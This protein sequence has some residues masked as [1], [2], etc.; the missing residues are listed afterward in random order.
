MKRKSMAGLAG[1]AALSAIAAVSLVPSAAHAVT[2]VA[3]NYDATGSTHISTT[4]STIPLGPTTLSTVLDVDTFDL[5]GHL[6]LP[7]QHNTFNL[8]GFVPVSADVSFIEAAP[9]QGHIQLSGSNAVVTSTASYYVKLSNVTLAGLPGFV[10]SNCMTKD[11]VNIAADTPAGQGF[12]LINGGELTGSYTLGSFH[13]CGI[14]QWLIN[15]VIPGSGNTADITVS[16]G[17]VVG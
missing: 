12:D 15:T 14:N 2:T 17:Q 5:T 16:N 7:T 4:G 13:N 6:P 10:G 8:I 9:V 3:I 11:P 1:A